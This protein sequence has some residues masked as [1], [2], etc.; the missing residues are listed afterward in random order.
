MNDEKLLNEI[1]RLQ[2]EERTQR[3]RRK[4]MFEILEHTVRD[5]AD[6][7]FLFKALRARHAELADKVAE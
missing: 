5:V 1:I 6:I 4:A 3:R 7:E 2:L